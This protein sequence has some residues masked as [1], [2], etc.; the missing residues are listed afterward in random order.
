MRSNNILG[1]EVNVNVK[2]MLHQQLLYQ[3]SGYI[4]AATATICTNA[5]KQ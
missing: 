5:T 3:R 2:R 4:I 1:E